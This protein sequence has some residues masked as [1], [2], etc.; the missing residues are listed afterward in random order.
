MNGALAGHIAELK[1]GRRAIILAHNYQ[2]PEVQ[3]IADHVGD[4]LGLAMTASKTDAEV[5]VFCGVDFMA[6]S[7]LILNPGKA[8]VMPTREAKCPMAAMITAAGL[9]RLKDEHPGVP[10]VS[11]VNTSAEVKTESDWCCTSSNAV[12]VVNAIPSEKIIFTPDTN[13]GLYIQRQVREKE[14]ILWPGYCP[15]HQNRITPEDL[16]ELKSQ[17]TSAEVVVHPECIP[18]VIEMADHVASTEGMIHYCRSSAATDFIIG[19]EREHT[20]RLRKEIPGKVFHAVPGAVCPNMKKTTLALVLKALETL[21]D[22]IVLPLEIIE[23]ARMPLD[24]MVMVGRGD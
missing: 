12:K 4:S 19:T 2:R 11:Y 9:R 14:I 24:R 21:E 17:H 7:A 20:Y 15:T 1:R 5:I 10:V 3:E 22:R 8:V 6:E 13:L 18:E 16:E 23:K